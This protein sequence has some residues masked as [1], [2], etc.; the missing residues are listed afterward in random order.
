MVHVN[1]FSK[2]DLTVRILFTCMSHMLDKGHAS[3]LAFCGHF[4]SS[5][6]TSGRLWLAF[7]PGQEQDGMWTPVCYASR[8]LTECQQRYSQTEKEALGVV[9][10]TDH[11][12]LEVICG[13][14]LRPCAQIEQWVLR[15]Q[16]YD[17][18]IL[19]RPGQGNIAD[20]LSRLLWREVKP[21]NHQQ[22]AEDYVSFVA[23]N[24]TP[25]ALTT[26]EIEEA[27][28]VDV[29][30]VEVRNFKAITS[31]QFEKCKQCMAVAG[32]LCVIGQLVLR[33]TRIVIPK[34]LQPRTLALAHEGYL[35]VVSTKQKLR[36]KVWWPRMDKAGDRHCRACHGCQLVARH[37]PLN[38][39]A[40]Q[41]YQMDPGRT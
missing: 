7:E 6:Q 3:I 19:H 20:L 24:E 8:S 4:S 34:M 15:L 28:T 38:Q 14:W 27:S 13:P 33:G 11:K 23:A 2:G 16:P 31:R 18:S 10:E 39:S 36:T 5:K 26:H 41:H 21:N 30:L 35:G 1:G 9:V 37:D 25:T 17:F 32:E 22:S 12:P 29:E 40:P